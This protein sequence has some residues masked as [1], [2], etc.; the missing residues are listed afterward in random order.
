MIHKKEQN[1]TMPLM[2]CDKCKLV[3]PLGAMYW[4]SELGRTFCSDCYKGIE[5]TIA[6]LNKPNI[7]VEKIEA[8]SPKG[9][10]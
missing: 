7:T 10:W 9:W 2:I 4:K 6:S 1:L 8:P 5:E 3:I